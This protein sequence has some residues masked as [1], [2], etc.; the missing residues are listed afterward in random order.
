[1]LS[2][3]LAGVRS[4][5]SMR[6]SGIAGIGRRGIRVGLNNSLLRIKRDK[7]LWGRSA[8]FLVCVCQSE[9]EPLGYCQHRI[10]L[11]QK[12]RP[13]LILNHRVPS[14][15]KK[16]PNSVLLKLFVVSCQV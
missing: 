2:V 12:L 10:R 5:G 16:A 13:K 11:H 1:M 7:A 14:T 9:S 15:E 6:W 8:L 4:M 3:S